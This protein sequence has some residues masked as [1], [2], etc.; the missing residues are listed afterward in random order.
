M[1]AT[2]TPLPTSTPPT[3]LDYAAHASAV[4]DQA[5]VVAVVVGVLVLVGLGVL[6]VR[7]VW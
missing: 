6:I 5:F 3:T 7:A 1:D 4:A 2:P